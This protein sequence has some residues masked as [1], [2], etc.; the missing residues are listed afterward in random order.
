MRFMPAWFLE[1]LDG[2]TKGTSRYYAQMLNFSGIMGRQKLPLNV[3]A[4]IGVMEKKIIQ[5]A[6]A[7]GAAKEA[8]A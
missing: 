2:W 1:P 6:H 4:F 3:W 7:K 5:E 8:A